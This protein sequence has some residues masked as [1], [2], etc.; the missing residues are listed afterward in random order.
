MLV[1]IKDRP[2]RGVATVQEI[3]TDGRV[4]R[5][6]M[7]LAVRFPNLC[8]G[9]AKTGTLWSVQGASSTR[10][11]VHQGFRVE[12]E[13]LQA[14]SATLHQINGIFLARWIARNVTGIG[15]VIARRLVRALPDL[16]RHVREQDLNALCSVAG[17]SETRARVL[18]DEWPSEGLYEVLDWLRCVDLPLGIGERLC[19]VYGE[20]ALKVLQRDPFSLLGFG[21]PFRAVH[22]IAESLGIGSNDERMLTGLAEHAVTRISA[23]TGSTVISTDQIVQ[24]IGKMRTGLSAKAIAN[25]PEIARTAGVLVA[26]PDGYQSVGH[27]LMERQVA[28]VLLEAANRCPGNGALF[29]AWE[30]QTSDS[31]VAKA[32]SSSE[33]HLPFPLTAEQQSVVTQAVQC[34][35]AVITGEAGT[36][37]TTIL[38]AILSVYDQIACIPI[39]QVALSGRAARRMTEATGRPASTIAKFIAEHL[40]EHKPN[41]PEHL[42]LIIDEASMVDLLAAYRLVGILPEATRFIF[43]GD[44]AQLP[45]VGPGLVFHALMDAGLPVFRLSQVKRHGADSQIHRFA[46][47]LRHGV[48]PEMRSLREL[49]GL[50]VDVNYTL[51]M[52]PETIK[53]IWLEAGGADRAMIL[54]PTRKGSGGVDEI[55]IYLQHTMG[56]DRPVVHYLDDSSGWIPWVGPQGYLFHLNDRVMVTVNDYEADVR[57]GD[58]GTIVDVFESPSEDGSGGMLD[59][60]GRDIPLTGDLLSSLSLGYAITIHK[61]QGSQWPV[62]I[63][64]LPGTALHMAERTLLYTAATRAANKLFIC[65]DKKLL[66]HAVSNSSTS[67][68]RRSNLHQYL[69]RNAQSQRLS[70]S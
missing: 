63:L 39:Y 23:R 49:A 16:D 5:R 24:E 43:V 31:D 65:G 38:R 3:A 59:I 15:E 29:A 20:S 22:V 44:V 19:R 62:C 58:L 35:V 9:A 30:R 55:N 42:L 50:P 32:L 1:Q 7:P 56:A 47:S 14:E 60:D 33:C 64:M 34:P 53:K 12:Q 28:Q 36:G 61:S 4:V 68:A 37:K 66:D 70:A 48:V 51:D 18:I 27:A 25:T 2:R 40:G 57:N 17:L 69:S 11:F 41:L 52:R 10:A 6:T 46:Q 26:V 67:F 13:V 21:I 54:S 8:I 45:P